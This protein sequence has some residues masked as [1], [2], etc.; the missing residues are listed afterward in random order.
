MLDEKI[1][2]YFKS[3]NNICDAKLS[4]VIKTYTEELTTGKN[5]ATKTIISYVSDLNLFLKFLVTH[6]GK[7]CCLNLLKE[8]NITTLRAWLTYRKSENLSFTSTARAISALR[9][10]FLF[11]TKRFNIHNDTVFTLSFPKKSQKLIKIL[12]VDEISQILNELA[13]EEIKWIAERDKALILLL[14]GSGLRISEAINLL[15]SNINV[16]SIKVMGKRAKE[17]MIPL[18]PF[19]KNQLD[20]YFALC[21]YPT[22]N[23]FT[24]YGLRGK[25]LCAT[26]MQKK[27]QNL[28]RQLGLSENTT[29]HT[30]RHCFA[31][32]LVLNGADLR[33]VQELLGHSNLSTTQQYTHLNLNHLQ[34]IYSSAHPSQINKKLT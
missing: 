34:K 25:K 2:F 30:L 19:V 7:I 12:E 11:L 8:L 26:I 5:S 28:R 23:N 3:I 20:L 10:F 6:Q 31:S 18:L 29:P 32:H 15:P 14:Y 16:D 4:E 22:D 9:N 13:K 17:R 27:I 21:P 1:K 33:S 24:F